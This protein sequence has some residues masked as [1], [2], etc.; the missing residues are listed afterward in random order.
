MTA[1]PFYIPTSSAQGFQF[2]HILTKDTCY[3]LCF[4]LIAILKCMEWYLIVV[5]SCIF[6]MSGDVENLLCVYCPFVCLLWGMI[7]SSP[8]LIFELG[9]LIFEGLF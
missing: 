3:F 1:A 6:L 2:L 5:L 9:P 4:F 7:Y 8:L